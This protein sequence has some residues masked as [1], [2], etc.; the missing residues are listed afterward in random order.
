[1]RTVL[2]KIQ[3]VFFLLILLTASHQLFA[4]ALTASVDSTHISR[5]ETLTLTLK[6]DGRSSDK[7]DTSAL[8]QQ[9]NIRRQGSSSNISIINGDMSSSTTWE[10]ELSPKRTGKLLIPSFSIDNEFSEAISIDVDEK[11]PDVTQTNQQLYTETTLDT[12]KVYTQ[13]QAIVTWRLISRMGP[14]QVRMAP[15]QITGVLLQDLGNRSY[16][17]TGS[18]GNSEWVIEQRYALFPQHSGAITIPSQTFQAVVNQT[19]QHISGFIISEPTEVTRDTEEQQLEVL[20]PPDTQGKNWLPASSVEISQQITGLDKQ[21]Q[22]TAGT[23]FTRTIH[24][25][26]KGLSAEQLPAPDMQANGVKVYPEKPTFDNKAGA[27]GNIGTRE[28]RVA[29]IA[30]QAG[31][32]ILPAISISWYDTETSQWK[33]AELPASTI[34]VLPNP[35]APPQAAT[36]T[37]NTTPTTSTQ[38]EKGSENTT[39]STD[40]ANKPV[41]VE[42]S[43]RNFIWP[44]V[45]G[46]LL[47]GMVLMAIYI[48]RLKNKVVNPLTAEQTRHCSNN[49]A[50][51]VQQ[52]SDIQR[53]KQAIQNNDW[54]S[55]YQLLHTWSAAPEHKTTAEQ[56]AF[57]NALNVLA[58][59]LYGKGSAPTSETMQ[60]VLALLE[61]HSKTATK[62]SSTAKGKSAQ[63]GSLY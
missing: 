11:S 57:Q 63:L 18:N 60:A 5:N 46:V 14:P 38:Q 20:P 27:Q 2:Q 6:Y 58:N 1:M 26:A 9:F 42:N 44:T 37:S 7:P 24:I 56:S 29:V 34:N 16:Q 35:S 43:A 41:S 36:P 62:G 52:S 31:K 21:S 48:Y 15:P 49:S 13:Q 33:T 55:A 3:Q 30:T 17:R 61:Q 25:R 40:V 4:G 32:L 8:E 59:H 22:A 23:A 19:Q 50:I 39:P 51:F 53:I 45:V 10:Y 54:Q 12:K 47:L 28:D